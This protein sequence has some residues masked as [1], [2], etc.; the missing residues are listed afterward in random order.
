M[1]HPKTSVSAWTFLSLV[2]L[3]LVF[4]TMTQSV[5]TLPIPVPAHVPSPL[6]FQTPVPAPVPFRISPAGLH[7]YPRSRSTDFHA[8]IV[9]RPHRVAVQRLRLTQRDDGG[10]T[11]EDS[12]NDGDDGNVSDNSNDS[13]DNYNDEDEDVDV[14]GDQDEDEQDDDHDDDSE[15]DGDGDGERD[16]EDGD[17]ESD[18][19]DDEG[20]NS[21]SVS[22][23]SQIGVGSPSANS[24]YSKASFQ[25]APDIN[26]AA[27]YQLVQSATSNPLK[28][29]D[30]AEKDSDGDGDSMVMVYGDFLEGAGKGQV[31]AMSF[32][33]DMDVDCDGSDIC[34]NDPDGQ[35]QTTYGS[36]DAS[37]VPYYVVPEDLIG[38]GG[39]F[40]QPNSLGA[41]ICGGKMFYAIM[42][43]TKHNALVGLL[44]AFA[45]F[46]FH[47]ASFSSISILTTVNSGNTPQRIGEG[48]L[49][50]A[51]T[52]FP[53]AGLGGDNGHTELDVAY[54][55]FGSVVPPGVQK[56]AIDIDALKRKGDKVLRA[57]QQRH[58][59][60][61]LGLGLG[62][63][64][65]SLYSQ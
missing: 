51:Q 1:M 44:T 42:G 14:S 22:I 38:V 33:A 50:L 47:F 65:G 20:A 2:R 62:L 49:L 4:L 13:D 60:T 34:P 27:I 30:S 24:S 11:D 10:Y 28:A 40:I 16:Q 25:A 18:N 15:E 9:E 21:N 3:S 17:S 53:D 6:A 57:F 32:I 63:G 8:V 56:S 12:D 41:I 29:Y 61:S 58:G 5:F 48:S 19:D 36:L 35:S 23:S 26:V 52:C 55:V 54:L 59:V 7:A 46:S 39:G 64:S 45:G 31:K 43:D 37:A